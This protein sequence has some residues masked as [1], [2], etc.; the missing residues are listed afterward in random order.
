MCC[1]DRYVH[2]DLAA[3]NVLVDQNSVMKIADFGLTHPFDEGKDG[4]KQMGVLKLS[5]RWLAIDSFDN[6]IFTEK[7]D[8]IL[9]LH[10]SLCIPMD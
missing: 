4:Y 8:G 9:D 3:R 10:R 5:I 2:M 1:D 7:A 6:K